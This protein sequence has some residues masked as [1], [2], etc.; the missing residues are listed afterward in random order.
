MTQNL[1]ESVERPNF[2]RWRRL[3]ETQRVTSHRRKQKIIKSARIIL[4]GIILNFERL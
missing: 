3:D 1:S 2:G 4:L